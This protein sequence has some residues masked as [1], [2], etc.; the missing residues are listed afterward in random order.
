MTQ[1]LRDDQARVVRN[2]VKPRDRRVVFPQRVDLG[3]EIEGW[4]SPFRRIAEAPHVLAVRRSCAHPQWM[5]DSASLPHLLDE[6]SSALD[7]VDRIGF[8][9]ERK[10]KKE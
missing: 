2:L 7:R 10:G 6:A 1:R 8:E 5:L 9:A 3:R 4:R